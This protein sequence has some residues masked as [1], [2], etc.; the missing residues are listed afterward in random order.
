MKTGALVGLGAVPADN[1]GAELGSSTT[2]ALDEQRFS[3][4]QVYKGYPGTYFG[5]ANLLD[6]PGGD[7]QVIENL[8]PV[9]KASRAVRTMAIGEIANRE[10][11]DSDI[12]MVYYKTFFARPLREMA[13]NIVIRGKQ[14]PGEI[15]PPGDDAVTLVWE[16]TTHLK[17]Y[18]LLQPYNSPKKISAFVMLDL[19]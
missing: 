10:L 8:R 13:R 16:S 2:A 9:D 1:T 12:A 3:V 17:I 11:N 14:F 6:V 18:L 4:T 5:D 7:F 15:Q 19:S